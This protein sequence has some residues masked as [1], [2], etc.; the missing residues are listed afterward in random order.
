MSRK[1]RGDLSIF[2]VDFKTSKKLKEFGFSETCTSFWEISID[3]PESRNKTLLYTNQI[4]K[5]WNNDKWSIYSAPT[6]AETL[7]WFRRVHNYYVYII[8]R[9]D[10]FDGSQYFCNYSIFREGDKESSDINGDGSYLYEEAEKEAI[11]EVLK[12]IEKAKP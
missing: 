3:A 10:G 6:R 11:N 1:L 4:E 8:P 9:F 5:D 12:F 2:T 7:E